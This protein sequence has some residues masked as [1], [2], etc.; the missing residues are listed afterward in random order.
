MI[1]NQENA[2][3]IIAPYWYEGIWVFDDPTVGLKREPFVLGVP[4]MI[5]HLVKEI[6]SAREG[7]RLIF[8]K[9]PFPGY[10]LELA[11]V[12]EEMGGNWY[13]AVEPPREGWLC[14]ALLKY[15]T[16]APRTIYVR[17]E[18]KERHAAS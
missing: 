18:S 9:A 1:E 10:Q 5:D 14:P 3:L 13:R 16:R 17:A 2:L 8:S 12:S 7:F 6:P 11:W 15:F 4:E